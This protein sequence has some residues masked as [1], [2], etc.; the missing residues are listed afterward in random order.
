VPGV[1]WHFAVGLIAVWQRSFIALLQGCNVLKVLARARAHVGIGTKRRKTA[2][3]CQAE[4]LA[5]EILKIA[6]DSSGDY[7]E[8]VLPGGHG[9]EP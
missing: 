8:K 9:P 4:D 3:E 6:D 2:V 7:V 5:D 1:G